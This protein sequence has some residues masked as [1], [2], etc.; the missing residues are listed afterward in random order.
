[1]AVLVALL[2]AVNVGGTGRLPM[3]ELREACT[4]AGLEQVSSYVA[5]GNLVFAS[6]K[7]ATAVKALIAGL[8][9]DRFGLGK[10][11]VII[12][13]P[14]ELAKVVAGNPFPD[15]AEAR[16][17]LMHVSFLEDR[18]QAGAAAALAAYKGPER[19]HLDGDCLY[20]DFAEGVARSKL[21]T[22]FL[23]KALKVAA[24][25]RNW[26]TVNKLLEMAR[27]IEP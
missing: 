17:N 9:R 14:A 2:R 26:N 1:M 5:S 21:T 13:T 4:Q 19:L 7:S 25:A 3:R 11:H 20:V 27:A 23:D 8:L 22:S 10:N 24:T 16:P 6:G 15:A 18:P 12:R